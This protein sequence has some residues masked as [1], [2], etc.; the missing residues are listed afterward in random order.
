MFVAGLYGA[1]YLIVPVY[2]TDI[3]QDSIR[4]AMTSLTM[5]AMGVGMLLSYLLGWFLTYKVMNYVCLSIS[6]AMSLSLVMLKE[7]PTF[8]ITKGLEEVSLIKLQ[9]RISGN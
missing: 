7:S 1:A 4:G 9:L 5:I 8:L 2:I 3:C 6:V